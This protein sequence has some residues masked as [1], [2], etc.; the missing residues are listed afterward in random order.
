MRMNINMKTICATLAA[1][2]TLT[3][4][5]TAEVNTPQPTYDRYI[6]ARNDAAGISAGTQ[7][8]PT[9]DSV[10]MNGAY[11]IVSAD[12]LGTNTIVGEMRMTADFGNETVDGTMHNNYIDMNGSASK[13]TG[14]VAFSGNI[15]DGT[16]MK[17]HGDGI[18]TT[19]ADDDYDMFV[20]LEGAF[21]N[22][23]ANGVNITNGELSG[24]ID[25]LNDDASIL[26]D[27]MSSSDFAVAECIQTTATQICR[28]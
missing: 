22:S 7:A 17:A 19:V 14:E 10:T 13:L 5:E 16:S 23:T 26:Y 20:D 4:C 6:D 12:L 2:A 25:V 27:V 18:L 28:P 9:N 11:E 15:I 21:G 3:A 1:V 8:L 24:N